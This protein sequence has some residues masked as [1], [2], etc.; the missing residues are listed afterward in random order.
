MIRIFLVNIPVVRHTNVYTE[1]GFFKR[2]HQFVLL[3]SRDF[4]KETE[5]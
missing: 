3:T 2:M 4:K 1:K 5:I